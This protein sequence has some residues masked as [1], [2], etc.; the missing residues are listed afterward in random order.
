MI[1]FTGRIKTSLISFTATLC[2]FFPAISAAEK[3]ENDPSVGAI[4]GDAIIARPLLLG[5]TAVGAV[6]Y[7]VSLPVTLLTG[8]ADDAADALV[9]GPAEATFLRCLGCTGNRTKPSDEKLFRESEEEFSD[10]SPSLIGLYLKGGYQNVRYFNESDATGYSA[11]IGGNLFD[12]N[13][14]YVDLE[15]NYQDFGDHDESVN[16]GDGTREKNTFNVNSIGLGANVGVHLGDH[17]N[18]YAKAGMNKWKLKQSFTSYETG[19]PDEK[20]S[21]SGNGQDKY[22][23][24]GLGANLNSR[25]NLSL[26]YVFHPIS[27]VTTKDDKIAALGANLVLKF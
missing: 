12:S 1:K 26:E 24:I 7:V 10:E 9:M 20:T 21:S 18:L 22:Y 19:E 8:D 15:L 13:I 23:G 6:L 14:A 25:I 4:V 16:N 3:V 11:A 5:V 17:F 27:K 2:L